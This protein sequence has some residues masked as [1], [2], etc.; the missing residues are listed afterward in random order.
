MDSH[1]NSGVEISEIHFE[2]DSHIGK[3]NDFT[4]GRSW[5]SGDCS[6]YLCLDCGEAA[7]LPGR[8]FADGEESVFHVPAPVGTRKIVL[9]PNGTILTNPK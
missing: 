4:K 6:S 5:K 1:A 9:D 7:P 3:R 8:V 2:R